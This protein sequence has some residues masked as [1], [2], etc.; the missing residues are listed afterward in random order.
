LTGSA[1]SPLKQLSTPRANAYI[2]DLYVDP[3]DSQRMWV[4]HRTVGGGR[5]FFS[6]DG[7]ASWQNRIGSGLPNLPINAIE[8]DPQIPDR[9]WVAA[10]LGVYET[11]DAGQNWNDFSNGLPHAYVGDLVFHPQARTLRA[12]TR[13]R[14]VWEIEVDKAPPGP[15]SGVQ[16]TGPLEGNASDRWYTTDWPALLAGDLTVMPTTVRPGAPP[17]SWTVQVER[18]SADKATYWI[19]VTNSPL[20]QWTSRSRYS[21]LQPHINRGE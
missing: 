4:T 18:A 14:G 20:T 15:V 19:T 9:V 11:L 2:S 7:G 13:N 12:G 16:F 6:G 3:N 8:M 1:W 5:V 21:V 10:D 17:A